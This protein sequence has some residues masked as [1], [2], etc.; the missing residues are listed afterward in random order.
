MQQKVLLKV[1]IEI[2]LIPPENDPVDYPYPAPDSMAIFHQGFVNKNRRFG[3]VSRRFRH[4]T[5]SAHPSP[6]DGGQEVFQSRDGPLSRHSVR[7]KN[8][9]IE[10]DMQD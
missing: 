9:V 4:S 1:N 2:A 3:V 5:F 6:G 8:G 10:V 7:D